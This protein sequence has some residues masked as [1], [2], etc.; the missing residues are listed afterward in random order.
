VKRATRPCKCGCD[1]VVPYTRRYLNKEHQIAHMR[2][3]EASRMN[4]L[5]P[6]EAKRRGGLTAGRLAAES[7]ALAQR[8]LR[9]AAKAHEVAEALRH[10]QRSA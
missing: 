8:G 9:G 2:S 6:Y 3:G 10:Q 5:Q 1:E 7:G 4:E